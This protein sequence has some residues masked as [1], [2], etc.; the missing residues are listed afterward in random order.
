MLPHNSSEGTH[1]SLTRMRKMAVVTKSLHA[2]ILGDDTNRMY[3]H[4]AYET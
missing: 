4:I 2:A 1:G 3:W